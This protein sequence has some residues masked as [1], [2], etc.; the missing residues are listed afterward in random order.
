MPVPIFKKNERLNLSLNTVYLKKR[1]L[2]KK[3]FYPIHSVIESLLTFVLRRS[4]II[5]CLQFY[6]LGLGLGSSYFLLLFEIYKT[7]LSHFRCESS[8]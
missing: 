2:F 3:L 8:I 5:L 4:M 7:N 1:I 6:I